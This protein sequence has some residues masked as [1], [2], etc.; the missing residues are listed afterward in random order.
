MSRSIRS[1]EDYFL[2]GRRL[3]GLLVSFSLFATWF[4]AE[5]CIGSSAAVYERGLA[6]S[7]TDP[8]GYSAWLLLLGLLRAGHL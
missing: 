8:F 2:G 7:R 4:G 3:G 1:E 5:T 6:G